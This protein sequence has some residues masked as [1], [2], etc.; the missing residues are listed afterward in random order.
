MIFCIAKGMLSDTDSRQFRSSVIRVLLDRNTLDTHDARSS[1]RTVRLVMLVR[2][3]AEVEDM[4]ADHAESSGRPETDWVLS[5]IGARIR[6][7]RKNRGMTL[8][9]LAEQAGY[10]EGYISAVETSATVPSLSALSTLS[11]VLRTD[12]SAFFPREVEPEVT[13]HRAGAPNHLKLSESSTESYSLLSSRLDDPSYTA[14]RHEFT[15]IDTSAT[16]RYL[17]ERFCLLLQG[18]VTLSFGSESFSLRPGE[19]LHYSS[20]PEHSLSIREGI[21]NV[22]MLWIVTPALVR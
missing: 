2:T 15:T 20:H 21:E 8:A 9:D 12:V 10:S 6:E 17:G 7:L 18:E 13:V 16:Y 14:L 19:S 4:T 11:A 3:R 1:G 5:N 22:E